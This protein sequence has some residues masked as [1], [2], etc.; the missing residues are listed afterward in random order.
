MSAPQKSLRPPKAAKCD[1]ETT[2]LTSDQPLSGGA[3]FS[4][5]ADDQE[6]D[7]DACIILV[8][9]DIRELNRALSHNLTDEKDLIAVVKKLTTISVNGMEITLEPKLL[10]RLHTRCVRG[11]FEAWFR[12]EIIRMLN[13]YVGI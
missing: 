5:P 10:H 3:Q 11:G 4:D 2:S 9:S 6:P 12:A 7:T 8:E 1:P 13:G